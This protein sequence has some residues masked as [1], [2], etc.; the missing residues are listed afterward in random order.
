M[1]HLEADVAVA[2]GKPTLEINER[3]GAS[4]TPGL[5]A[6]MRA[7]QTERLP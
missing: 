5:P 6:I 3:M 1:I 7:L 2:F 4:G